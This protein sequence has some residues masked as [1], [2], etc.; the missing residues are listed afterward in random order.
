MLRR[1]EPRRLAGI[2]DADAVA[3]VEHEASDQIE[4]LLHARHDGDLLEG[5]RHPAP[6]EQI[7]GDGLSQGLVA[8]RIAA[9]QLIDGGAAQR[10]ASDLRPQGRRKQIER[11][12]IRAERPCPPRRRRTKSLRPPRQ[13]G[14]TARRSRPDRD[15]RGPCDLEERIGQDAVHVRPGAG[16]RADVAL[17]FHLLEGGDDGPARQA[18][19]TGEIAGGGKAGARTQAA[20]QDCGTERRAEPSESGGV[21]WTRRQGQRR[22]VAA[23]HQAVQSESYK[24][25]FPMVQSQL[26]VSGMRPAA[27]IRGKWTGSAAVLAAGILAAGAVAAARQTPT[28]SRA[29]VAIAQALPPLDG[30]HLE[31]TVVEVT[32]EP[33]GANTAH[34]H[35]CPVIGYVLDGRLR[36]QVEGRPEQIFAAGDVFY[37]SPADVHVIPASANQDKPARFL[38]YFVCDKKTPLSVPVKG[39]SN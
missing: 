38:A 9:A 24:W 12:L 3:G 36:M 4:R 15:S 31:A 7:L 13:R 37:E 5:A 20:V 35:P 26:N 28:P 22:T 17:R 25:T 21:G 19:L 6:A 39:S 29:H 16:A 10:A 30:N 23:Y 1:L 2:L 18:A 8:E 33:G 34:R 11:G 14:Q 27:A 32:Y